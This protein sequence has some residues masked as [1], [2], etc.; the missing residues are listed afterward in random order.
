MDKMMIAACLSVFCGVSLWAA[1]EAVDDTDV[2]EGPEAKAFAVEESAPLKEVADIEGPGV[3]AFAVEKPAPLKEVADIGAPVAA[4]TAEQEL[5]A[6][7][8]RG[9]PAIKPAVVGGGEGVVG[10]AGA[11]PVLESETKVVETGVQ[12]V[13]AVPEV[14]PAPS[15]TPASEEGEGSEEAVASKAEAAAMASGAKEGI[16]QGVPAESSDDEFDMLGVEDVA[17]I[18]G[19]PGE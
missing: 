14:L 9:E 5:L 11:A 1:T 17:N 8:P 19:Q 12:P 6:P 2:V 18:H 3:E 10:E 4:V 13:A 15:V 7:A 16:M